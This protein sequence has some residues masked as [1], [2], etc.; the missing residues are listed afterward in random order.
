MGIEDVLVKDFERVVFFTGAGMSAESGVPTYRGKGGIWKQYDYSSYA[1]QDAFDA[2]PDK[3]WEFH[4][5]R[6]GL[7]GAC[8]PNE[9][10][11]RIAQ[12]EQARPATTVVTQNIDGLHQLAGSQ[13]VVELHGSL[14][15][16]RCD[17]CGQRGTGRDAPL[18]QLQCSCGAWWRP[19]IVWFGDALVSEVIEAAVEAISQCD[20]LVSIGT[21][22]VVYPAAQLPL[23]ARKGGAKLVEVNPEATPMSDVYDVCVRA[24]ASEAL[25]KMCAGLA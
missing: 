21:S 5:Y 10:H 2:D 3:V 7:V 14:W 1:C 8:A 9:G 25:A 20:L 13:R 11:R 23:L 17:R 6:R 18:S 24:S 12:M 4:N 22:A 15:R 19:D 16:V